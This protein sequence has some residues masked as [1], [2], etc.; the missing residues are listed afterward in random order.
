MYRIKTNFLYN[1]V[2]MKH[3]RM[4]CACINLKVM[5]WAPQVI[6]GNWSCFWLNDFWITIF[7]FFC[8]RSCTSSCPFSLSGGS[9]G[10]DYANL[11]I[12]FNLRFSASADRFSAVLV[13]LNW[14]KWAVS[15]IGLFQFDSR[16]RICGL[17]KKN[18]YLLPA[19]FHFINLN[20]PLNLLINK[21]LVL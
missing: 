1:T 17:K 9:W 21:L 12:L 16:Y 15:L 18:F 2:A 8:L 5:F 20:V 13:K 3:Y 11:F 7:Y 10:A 6:L 14:R 19:Q 4:F